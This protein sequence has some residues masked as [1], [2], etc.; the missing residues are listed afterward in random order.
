VLRWPA[1]RLNSFFKPPRRYLKCQ[2]AFRTLVVL[3]R[4][5]YPSAVLNSGF[6]GPEEAKNSREKFFRLIQIR[7]AIY[8]FEKILPICEGKSPRVLNR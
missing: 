5:F 2:V 8:T 3:L 6:A 7:S 1:S 4:A